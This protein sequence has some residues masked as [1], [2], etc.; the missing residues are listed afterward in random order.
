MANEG[1]TVR[2]VC[3]LIRIPRLDLFKTYDEL[4]DRII[5]AHKREMAAVVAERDAEILR[6]ATLEREMAAKDAAHRQW[7]EN[8]HAQLAEK[9]AEIERL[10]TALKPVL[11]CDVIFWEGEDPWYADH[12]T[13][14]NASHGQTACTTAPD[15]AIGIANC[16]NAVRE[17]QRVMRESYKGENH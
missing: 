11:A 6:R 10:K 15:T 3:D 12:R 4:A 16:H 8:Y 17:A 5:A 9:D 7:R 14:K 13:V 1:E 2:E